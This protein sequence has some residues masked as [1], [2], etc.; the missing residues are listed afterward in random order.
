[1]CSSNCKSRKKCLAEV[2]LAAIG[3]ARLE[4]WGTEFDPPMNRQFKHTKLLDLIKTSG[5]VS[6]ADQT[7]SYKVTYFNSS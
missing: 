4:F 5:I 2:R 1:V 3:E 7:V 6:K